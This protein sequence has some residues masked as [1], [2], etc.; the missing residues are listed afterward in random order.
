MF[1]DLKRL[2]VG[3]L[4]IGVGTVFLRGL[5]KLA[6][7]TVRHAVPAI[8]Q[9]RTFAAAGSLMSYGT[10]LL[11]SYR[12]TGVYAGRVLKAEN[13]AELPVVQATKFELVINLKTAKAFGIN[14]PPSMRAYS[15]P[16]RM[17]TFL[18][19]LIQPSLPNGNMHS[20]SS[21]D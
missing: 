6:A 10:D 14:V 19:P 18:P 11:D 20:I 16:Q 7:L 4:V 1:A 12:L 9:Y 2:H 13:P 3:G 17:I 5:N 8:Y 15:K 21:T